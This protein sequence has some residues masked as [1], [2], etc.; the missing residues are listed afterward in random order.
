MRFVD[1]NVFIYAVL[2]P[3]TSIPEHIKK[4]K[5]TARQIFLR[6]NNGEMV[7]TSTVHLSEVANVLEDVAGIGFAVDFLSA[8]F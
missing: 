2:S 5:E 4:K 7:T 3:K 8:V 1:T 6:I